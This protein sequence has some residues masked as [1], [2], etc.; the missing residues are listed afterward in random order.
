MLVVMF[1]CL[2]Q[3][4]FVESR[5]IQVKDI[6]NILLVCFIISG[7]LVN[8]S[9][10]DSMLMSYMTVMIVIYVMEYL[11]YGAEFFTPVNFI[12]SFI[13]MSFIFFIVYLVLYYENE[14]DAQKINLFIQ[15]HIK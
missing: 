1:N 13:I 7:L 10:T 11:F 6:Y 14:K 4:F 15:K 2:C 12:F 8:L 9:I 3:T 5:A